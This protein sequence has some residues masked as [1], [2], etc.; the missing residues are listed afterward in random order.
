MSAMEQLSPLERQRVR[1]DAITALDQ[2]FSAAHEATGWCGDVVTESREAAMP[3]LEEW[4][5]A[6]TLTS[7]N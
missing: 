7:R 3:I 1:T 2:I 6:Y 5:A 4:F